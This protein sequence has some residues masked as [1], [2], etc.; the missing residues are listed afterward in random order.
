MAALALSWWQFELL[1][2]LRNQEIKE[3]VRL[4]MPR[5]DIADYLGFAIETVWRSFSPLSEARVIEFAGS[6]R[7][8][9]EPANVRAI[10][11]SNA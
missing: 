9:A 5:Q 8:I 7:I 2:F 11:L 1:I 4:L 6:R 3:P 10:H